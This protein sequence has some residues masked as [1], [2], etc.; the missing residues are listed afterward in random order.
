[1]SKSNVKEFNEHS[2]NLIEKRDDNF[3]MIKSPV[4]GSI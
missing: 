3:Q 4:A 1:M 2:L